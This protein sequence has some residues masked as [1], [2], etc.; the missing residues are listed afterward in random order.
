[1]S[2]LTLIPVTSSDL[3]QTF[4]MAL[5]G[6][7]YGFEFTWNDRDSRW[8]MDLLD[9]AGNYVLTGLPVVTDYPL[10]SRFHVAGRPPGNIFAIDTLGAGMDAGKDDLGNRVVLIYESAT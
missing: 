3:A 9:D 5:D 7:Q 6:N 4:T 2:T 1:M 8:Y 10:I